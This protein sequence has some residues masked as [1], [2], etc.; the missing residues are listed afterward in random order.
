MKKNE[1]IAQYALKN[2]EFSAE[3][4]RKKTTKKEF[5][6]LKALAQTRTL[7]LHLDVDETVNTDAINTD[8]DYKL[9][10]RGNA[11]EGSLISIWSR[12]ASSHVTKKADYRDYGVRIHATTFTQYAEIDAFKELVAEMATQVFSHK[13]GYEVRYTFNTLADAIKFVFDVADAVNVNADAENADASAETKE[14]DA[15]NAETSAV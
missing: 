10:H 2:A 3:N 14:I 5:T 7:D 4:T 8:I 1:F 15:E 9:A 13:D 12:N 6:T 11:K